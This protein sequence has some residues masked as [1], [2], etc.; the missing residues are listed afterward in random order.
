MDPNRL[1]AKSKPF[2]WKEND[3][4]IASLYLPNH[5]EDVYRAAQ[6]ILE[7]TGD[8]QL[9]ALGLDPAVW[10]KRFHQVVLLGSAIHDLGK[11]ASNQ[12]QRMIK[13]K[14]KSQTKQA[15][16]HEWATLLIL[17][18][19]EWEIWL[20]PALAPHEEDWDILRWAVSGHHPKYGRT[21]PPG[22]DEGH[23][24]VKVSTDHEDFQAIVK[25][26][27]VQFQL[28]DPP[29]S[30]ELKFSLT[31]E[32]DNDLD[33]IAGRHYT[34]EDE[35]DKFDSEQRRFVAAVKNCLIA[36]DIAGSALPKLKDGSK[37][38][39]WIKDVL[40]SH[41]LPTSQSY[42]QI[43]ATALKKKGITCE[44]ETVESHMRD[45][46]KRV[47]ASKSRVTFVRAGCGTGKTL[48]A[49]LWA[50][51]HCI[52]RRLFFCYPTTGTST[53][54]FADYLLDPDLAQVV[55]SDL[56]HGRRKVDFRILQAGEDRNETVARISSLE[57][58]RTSIIACTVDTVLG[59]I[60]NNRR[61]MFSWPALAQAGFVFDEIHSYDDKLFDALLH[62][63]SVV[64][65]V[66]ILLMTA[67]LQANRL[68]AIRSILNSMDEELAEIP[69]P[70]DM[71]KI[72]RYQQMEVMKL[73][74][75][76]QRVR[77]ELKNGGKVL[78]VCN[79]VSEVLRTAVAIEDL[80]PFIYHS[81]FRYLDRV[82]QHQAVV[83]AFDREK[84]V[85]AFAIC[86]Q[87]AEC[88]LDLSATLLV[89]TRAP[90]PALIQRLGRLNRVEKPEKTCPFIV[91]EP[92]GND[93]KYSP[94]P[95][96]EDELELA[97]QWLEALGTKPIS[98][99][100]LSQAWEHLASK[101]DSQPPKRWQSA[102]ID[103]GPANP[104]LELRE[105]SPTVTVIM[106]EDWEGFDKKS[107]DLAEIA[108]PMPI[109]RN[110][111]W[112]LERNGHRIDLSGIPVA[113][114]DAI[115]YSAE[116]GAE[117]AK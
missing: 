47:A 78:W 1:W 100:D 60:Q 42:R 22:R 89:T 41:S 59:V 28:S 103:Y 74:D 104:V 106:Q 101:H 102:W 31:F 5:L 18:R 8:A 23:P 32:K 110:D 115:K 98:Q 85:A 35:F 97:K 70:E 62:F 107:S 56:I 57:T 11:A 37:S 13:A 112:Q 15:L 66:P 114:S 12:F 10:G 86:S 61:G 67:S 99:R 46:Q 87:V 79:T 16:R 82:K 43:I 17:D 84:K 77:E 71:E 29:K 51:A 24:T 14:D 4:R 27:K 81:R 52:N 33:K 96:E 116:R 76:E 64:R 80:K 7:A 113:R 105:G 36:A 69:G 63:L 6:H 117:W 38:D 34:A 40:D 20:K 83:E 30:G 39:T 19:P 49:D 73:K 68:D 3:P 2:E 93:G 88:S 9:Q 75:V 45:F 21:A 109:R 72:D 92:T 58:W 90:V 48:A 108:L 65:G 55:K 26:L 95:Y 54:G 111:D 94:L 53:A 50:A 25:W 91:I 44:P